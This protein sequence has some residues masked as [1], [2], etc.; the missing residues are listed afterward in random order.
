MNSIPDK[1]SYSV[2]LSPPAGSMDQERTTTDVYLAA[3]GLKIGKN[4]MLGIFA[5]MSD[6]KRTDVRSVPFTTRKNT[7]RVF[8]T[9]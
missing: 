7:F 4:Y 9:V 3:S 1:A 5:T 2:N 8:I 6:G